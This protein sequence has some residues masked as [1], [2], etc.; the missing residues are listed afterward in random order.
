MRACC[1]FPIMYIRNLLGQERKEV[2][3]VA[4]ALLSLVWWDRP[5]AGSCAGPEM[6]RNG[7]GFEEYM[8]S[9]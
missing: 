4:A 9:L 1:F 6:V 5:S 8:S 2:K 7:T 3:L